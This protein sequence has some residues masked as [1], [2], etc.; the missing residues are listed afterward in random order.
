MAGTRGDSLQPGVSLTVVSTNGDVHDSK[1]PGWLPSVT[2]WP[3]VKGEDLQAQGD[4][5]RGSG[6]GNLRRRLRHGPRRHSMPK[7][8]PPRVFRG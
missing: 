3:I 2:T 5:S 1:P 6:A 4:G 8:R 7:R